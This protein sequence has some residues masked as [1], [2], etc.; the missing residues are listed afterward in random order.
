[1][2]LTR[3]VSKPGGTRVCVDLGHKAV[4]SEGPH[5]RVQLL[6]PPLGEV[7]FVGHSEEHL[8]FETPRAFELAVG[9]VCYG[10]PW[11]VCPTVA[12]HSEAFV[13]TDGRV[14]VRWPIR[15]RDRR[16]TV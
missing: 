9:D 10:V 13:V 5:P 12:L 2:L 1:V 7:T 15:A 4:A 11:H 8:V 14:T 3:V 16:L 6:D